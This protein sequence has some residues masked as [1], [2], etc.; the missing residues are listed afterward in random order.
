MLEI[1]HSYQEHGFPVFPLMPDTKI[2]LK[3]S[4]G[5]KDATTDQAQASEWWQHNPN[6][7]IG[8]SLASMNILMLD[9]DKGHTS[10]S[11]GFAFLKQLAANH[12]AG[13]L[14]STYGET[15]PSGGLHLF[16]TYPDYLSMTARAGLFEDKS[17]IDYNALGVPIAPDRIGGGQYKRLNN[18]K[19]LTDLVAAPNW[20]LDEIQRTSNT[21]K[22]FPDFGKA[23]KKYTGQLLDEIVAGSVQGSRNTYLTRMA[24]R[25]FYSD[26]DPETVYNL[27]LV[28]NDRF[29]DQPLPE[30]EINT[31]FKSVLKSEQR[32]RNLAH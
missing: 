22:Y 30:K 11:D 24:G 17:G 4:H 18:D 2:P 6:Y 5:Y 13:E 19:R 1:A 8:I 23:R 10:G 25:M 26:A 31:I 32:R 9:I 12:V 7:N 16:Y 27:L 14:P 20:L 3:G 29:I 28:I 15:T 21:R